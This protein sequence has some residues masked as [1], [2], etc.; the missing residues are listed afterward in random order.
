MIAEMAGM[1]MVDGHGAMTDAE[2]KDMQMAQQ[3]QDKYIQRAQ[4]Q[5]QQQRPG[6]RQGGNQRGQQQSRQ[7]QELEEQQRAMAY[8][9]NRNAAQ[10][11]GAGGGQPAQLIANQRQAPARDPHRSQRLSEDSDM[12]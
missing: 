5:S 9:Q 12:A 8:Y 4:R 2:I 3:L 11:N 7:Q 6:G 10:Q 1:Q